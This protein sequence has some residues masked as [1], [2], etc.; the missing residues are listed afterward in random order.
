MFYYAMIIPAVH[1]QLM[2][3]LLVTK[4]IKLP[5]RLMLFILGFVLL[6]AD[7]SFAITYNMKFLVIHQKYEMHFWEQALSMSAYFW[8]FVASAA[9]TSGLLLYS[10]FARLSKIKFALLSLLHLLI[11][12]IFAF[13]YLYR[14]L[15]QVR[16]A[17]GEWE[18]QSAVTMVYGA[19]VLLIISATLYLLIQLIAVAHSQITGSDKPTA[20]KN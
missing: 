9:T 10:I 3:L 11:G 8:F 18:E 2:I 5:V 13:S 14:F 17:G 15:Q 12:G 20:S 1:V 6:V 4:N 16:I 7:S 19:F